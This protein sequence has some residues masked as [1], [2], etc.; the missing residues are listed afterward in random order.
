[1]LKEF[2]EFALKGNVLD[3]AIGIIIGAAF[4]PSSRRWSTTSSC[5]RSAS[6]LGGVDFSQL[7]VVL[8]GD[9]DY[10]TIAQ[11]KEAGAVTWNIGLFI[12][13]VI[14]F[15]IV[16]FAVFLLVKA[17]NK[18]VRKQ[19]QKAPEAP[20]PAEDVV[21]LREIR[22]LLARRRSDRCTTI[23]APIASHQ[24]SSARRGATTRL[25]FRAA[26]NL[27]YGAP[28]E[29]RSSSCAAARG[30][31][32]AEF[33]HRRG[34][35]LRPRPRRADP[36]LGRRGRP[37]DA[38]LHLRGGRRARSRPARPSTPGSAAFRS[39][40]PRS[41]AITTRQF[42]RDFSPERF[43]VTGGGMQAI[44]IAIAARGRHRRRGDRAEPRPGRISPR[45]AGIAGATAG[46]RAARLRRRR[47][48]RSTST[49]CAA[50][51]SP[52][53]AR[54]LHQLAVQ[55]DRLD[56][57]PR[58]S[59]ARSSRCARERGLWIIADEVYSRFVYDGRARAVLLR[60]RRART[61][62]SSS[63]TPSP[64]TGR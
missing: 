28:H 15:L 55:P 30:A 49:G 14:K 25:G 33:G 31:R 53:D 44:Q 40:A 18:L 51:I 12:N 32:G 22:D 20:P 46:R 37:A 47:A 29:R 1:M 4:G 36:A 27:R 63:S 39:C 3:L 50:A 54:D 17:I 6:S 42:G 57:E 24:R 16:A 21:L 10:N 58:T 13:A 7:F 45:A 48:G 38:G 52:R 19:E 11:A 60:R 5:R 41:P 61:T 26:P 62:A 56:G 35:Q 9:G 43:F 2:K 34:L 8:K 59:C 64:R 23:S